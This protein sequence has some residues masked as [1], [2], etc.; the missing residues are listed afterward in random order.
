MNFQYVSD[1]LLKRKKVITVFSQF[2]I[3]PQTHTFPYF[4]RDPTQLCIKVKWK[5]L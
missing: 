5:I 4:Q 2:I 3:P 1:I